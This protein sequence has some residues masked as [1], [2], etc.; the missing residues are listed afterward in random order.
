MGARNVPSLYALENC[1]DVIRSRVGNPTCK[2]TASSG[3]VFYINSIGS[4]IA[5]VCALATLLTVVTDPFLQDYS[6]PLTRFCMR[7]YP[8][9]GRGSMS[10]VHHGSK[11]LH[12]LPEELLAPSV[13][14]DR[15][16]YFRNELLQSTAGFFI[17]IRFFQGD[18]P[19]RHSGQSCLQV[20]ALGHL[21]VRT[22]V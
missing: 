21:V 3:N 12:E 11:M 4:A 22:E 17:P 15:K 19:S 2:V 8:E 14:V 7:D 6:N 10:Q 5:M 1:Q 9:D 13:R 20:L 18:I 16:I